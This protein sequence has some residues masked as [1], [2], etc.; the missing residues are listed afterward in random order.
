MP[1]RSS[2]PR[3]C[4]RWGTIWWWGS[5]R[6]IRTASCSSTPTPARPPSPSRRPSSPP[7]ARSTSGP[8]CSTPA[9]TSAA[10]TFWPASPTNSTTATSAASSLP[11]AAPRRRRDCR[12]ASTPTSSGRRNMPPGSTTP[13]PMPPSRPTCCAG[14]ATLSFPTT[15]PRDT[16]RDIATSCRDA[17]F[18]A[19]PT[20]PPRLGAVPSSLDP[21]WWG[22]D[23]AS[24]RDA[25][26]REPSLAIIVPSIPT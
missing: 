15:C 20:I 1:R 4:G 5:T 21:A 9:L 12:T 16:K 24:A 25:S 19:R 6:T 18:T 11:T 2:E 23:V 13:G 3:L 10:R 8:T 14:G 17:T 22:A 7:T 26:S